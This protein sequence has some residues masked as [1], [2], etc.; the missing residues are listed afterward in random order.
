MRSIDQKKPWFGGHKMWFSHV[1]F[2]FVRCLELWG[3]KL[4]Y[5]ESLVLLVSS[6]SSFDGHDWELKI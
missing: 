4:K 2:W 3:H 5:N 6:Q 1:S